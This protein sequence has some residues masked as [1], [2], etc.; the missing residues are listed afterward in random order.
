[1]PAAHLLGVWGWFRGKSFIFLRVLWCS[2]VLVVLFVD[3]WLWW[4][5][6]FGLLQPPVSNAAQSR[7]STNREDPSNWSWPSS[8]R[9]DHH[10]SAINISLKDVAAPQLLSLSVA[11]TFATITFTLKI[12]A[13]PRLSSLF[14]CRQLFGDILKCCQCGKVI[15]KYFV[16]FSCTGW[17]NFSLAT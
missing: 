12:F 1:M 16:S 3:C 5:P 6:V 11:A 7:Q 8:P 15:R 10:Q 13:E 2:H 17:R 9:L 14:H 4:C